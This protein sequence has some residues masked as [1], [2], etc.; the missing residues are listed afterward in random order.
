MPTK[1]GIIKRVVDL[2]VKQSLPVFLV[3]PK[4]ETV[5]QHSEVGYYAFKSPT[6]GVDLDMVTASK[7]FLH[8]HD[9]MKLFVLNTTHKAV[10]TDD[11][12]EWLLDEYYNLNVIV[13][14]IC[15]PDPGMFT[16]LISSWKRV[17][18]DEVWKGFVENHE[19]DEGV[20]PESIRRGSVLACCLDGSSE[21]IVCKPC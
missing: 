3:S 8:S 11:F 9:E 7:D 1:Y 14:S 18:N 4:L 5:S 13:L 10:N 2:F 12:L 19:L 21:S 20:S 17:K 15:V 6:T 16:G